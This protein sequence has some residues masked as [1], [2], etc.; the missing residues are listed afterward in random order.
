MTPFDPRPGAE[1]P[2]EE[3]LR[4]AVPAPS[5]EL[6]ER[7][8]AR[9]T[10]AREREG[11]RAPRRWV[12]T[13]FAVAVAAAA[14]VVHLTDRHRSTLLGPEYAREHAPKLQIARAVGTDTAPRAFR[15]NPLSSL[16]ADGLVP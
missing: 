16:P 4:A 15:R 13:G 2:L 9:A 14:L 5:P 8:L 7:V 1:G 11:R 10:A 3:R 6:K 12:R